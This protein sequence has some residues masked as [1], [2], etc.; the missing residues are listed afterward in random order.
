MRLETGSLTAVH[1]VAIAL[2]AISGAIHL[3]LAIIWPGAVLR[4]SFALAGLGFF[5]GIA[6]VAV[7]YRRSM[8]YLLGIPYVA[9][10]IVLWYVIV[11]P[12]PATI[13]TLD[14]IDKLAQVL[15]IGVLGYLSRIDR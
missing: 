3:V 12:T 10:Q 6:L 14:A 1:W 7:G 4:L 2:A 15:L 8:L 5:G 11:E 9:V 13:D